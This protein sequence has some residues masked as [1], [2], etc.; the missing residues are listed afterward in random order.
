[1]ACEADVR[2]ASPHE[3]VEDVFVVLSGQEGRDDDG[4]VRGRASLEHEVGPVGRA[5]RA[6]NGERNFAPV[7]STAS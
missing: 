2:L 1:M 6:A 4:V 5:D 3:L 7:S